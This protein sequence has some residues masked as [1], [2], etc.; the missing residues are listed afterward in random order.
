MLLPVQARLPQKSK[1]RQ[2]IET[3]TTSDDE[4][5]QPLADCSSRRTWTEPGLWRI[6][7]LMT[8]R[9]ISDRLRELSVEPEEAARAMRSSPGFVFLESSLAQAT[10]ISLLAC[11]PDFVIEG[12]ATEWAILEGALAE[13]QRPGADLGF[14]DGAAIGWIGF[15]G[16]FRF[17]FY[18]K[19]AV[20][21]HAPGL[22]HN[23]RELPDL[24]DGSEFPTISF[25]ARLKRAEFE[26]MVRVAQQYIAAGDIYQVCLAH[27]FEAEFVG[28]AWPFYESLRHRS[29][30]TIRRF[31]RSWRNA[32][33]FR[34]ARVLSATER[35]A[36]RDAPDQG[37]P[38]QESGSATRSTQGLRSH[39]IRQGN[40]RANHDHG[41]RTQRFGPSL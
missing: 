14:P 22:W 26:R 20:F 37:H 18:E 25:Q 31:S 30:R 19:P 39:H 11:E 27:P 7:S 17:G 4:G 36:Y 35:P 23:A 6:F 10:S 5:K 8:P 1:Q 13:R 33:R 16:R 28:D 9:R 41:S 34:L 29:P 24:R 40:R 32:D 21:L 15:D 12:G 38:S 3:W 2:T